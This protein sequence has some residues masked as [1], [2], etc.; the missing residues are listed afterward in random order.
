MNNDIIHIKQ[1]A[2]IIIEALNV[3]IE[4]T[5]KIVQLTEL[6]GLTQTQ[7]NRLEASLNYLHLGRIELLKAT[8]PND[9]FFGLTEH[10]GNKT[11][12]IKTSN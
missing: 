6:S 5:I 4:P 7:K 11:R 1:N 10:D 3:L 9:D 8:Y 12:D 2:K